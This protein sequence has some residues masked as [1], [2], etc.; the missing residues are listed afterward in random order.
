MNRIRA[1]LVAAGQEI[2]LLLFW[3]RV[4]E[5]IHIERQDAYQKGFKHGEQAERDRALAEEGEKP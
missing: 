3:G 2:A 1:Y 4:K 5:I